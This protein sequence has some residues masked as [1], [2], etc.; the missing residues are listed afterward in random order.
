MG[1]CDKVRVLGPE[2]VKEEYLKTLDHMRNIYK[3]LLQNV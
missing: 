2:N 1:Y 3:G